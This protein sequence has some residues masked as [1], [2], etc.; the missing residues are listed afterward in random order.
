MR[1]RGCE[2]TFPHERLSLPEQALSVL[3]HLGPQAHLIERAIQLDVVLR[4]LDEDDV[5]IARTADALVTDCLARNLHAAV[6]AMR[7]PG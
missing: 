7:D 1:F 4:A 5:P 3:V 2:Q 6:I